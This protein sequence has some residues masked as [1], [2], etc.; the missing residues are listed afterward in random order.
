MEANGRAPAS[1]PAER[2]ALDEVLGPPPTAWLGGARRE[3]DL[4]VASADARPGRDR[5][6]PALLALQRTAGTLTPGA[7]HDLARRLDLPPSEVYG[8]ASFYALL[9][10][11]SPAAATLHVCDDI[12]CSLAGAAEVAA[13]AREAIG[14]E[15]EV[16]RGGLRWRTSPCLGQ[17]DRA[18]AAFLQ[19]TGEEDQVLAP[20]SLPWSAWAAP[21]PPAPT[22]PPPQVGGERR[23]LA[24]VEV[25]D[26]E[27]LDAY[28]AHGGYEALRRA[29]DLGPEGVVRELAAARLSGRGGAAFPTAAKW[30]AVARQPS[31]PHYVVANADESEPG[32]FKDRVLLEGDPF[33]LVEALTIAGLAT[34][35]ERGYVFVRAEYPLARARIAHAVEVA[36]R[37]GYLGRGIL[38]RRF[39]FDVEVR[40]GAG[41]YVCGEET[42]LFQA[43][44]GRRGEPR[45]KPP[46]PT[47]KGLFGKPTAV[48]NVETLA[49]VPLILRLGGAAY[50]ADADADATGTRLFAVSGA[51][52]RP[53]VYEVRARVTLG[54][55]I[56]LAGGAPRGVRA[57]LLGGAAG[58]FVGPDALDMPLSPAAARARAATLGSGAV[59]VFPRGA[60]LTAAVGRI[61]RF[62]RDESCGQCV[63]CRIGTVR[64][65]ELVRRLAE[66][67]PLGTAAEERALFDDLARAMRDASICGLGQ[68]APN[69]VESALRLGLIAGEGEGE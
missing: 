56:G 64:Q 58:A 4:H 59:V 11:S 15:G 45:N 19:R 8:V 9:T 42:A 32:T 39:D 38:G 26:P 23:L 34:G 60:D 28:R 57:V 63:P 46:Y 68:S 37:R 67:S 14:P 51:V 25:V 30:E 20:V 12:A 27:D 31:R 6:L 22:P 16:G 44:E 3:V 41:A 52:A 48:N 21:R 50:A 18:P 49:N 7:V 40:S 10:Q 54:D 35:A 24:R 33:A 53:G 47:A 55:L 43:I 36:R 69:A 61:A 2:A 5:L 17:C 1:D 29:L 62:F 65:E 66:G 13:Q